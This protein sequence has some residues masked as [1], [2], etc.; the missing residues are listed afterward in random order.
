MKTVATLAISEDSLLEAAGRLA[1][2][3]RRG[4]SRAIEGLLAPDYQGFDPA[5]R[6]QDRGS[7]VSAYAEGRV[8]IEAL[9]QTEVRARIIGEVGLVAGVTALAGC[10]GAEK[11]DF[12]LRFLDVYAWREGR[13]Q[14][15]ASQHTRLPR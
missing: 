9:R 14:L 7:V 12:Q 5:G 4:D 2:A 1:Q 3:E 11:F 6:P 13:W 10:L 15:H 8:R